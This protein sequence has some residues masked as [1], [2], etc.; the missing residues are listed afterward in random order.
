MFGRPSRAPAGSAV[1]AG[2]RA[3]AGAVADCPRA[4][5]GNISRGQPGIG[6][7]T[8]QVI[9]IVVQLH[10][11]Q[12]KPREEDVV[13]YCRSRSSEV[14]TFCT[15]EPVAMNTLICTDLMNNLHEF[16]LHLCN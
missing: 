1:Y 10:H 9:V 5:G 7:R 4:R 11:D 3:R 12:L 6:L 13:S 2:V 16:S 8:G 15:V 14:S